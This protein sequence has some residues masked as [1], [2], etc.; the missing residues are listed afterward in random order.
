[1][2]SQKQV[3]RQPDKPPRI[4]SNLLCSGFN[5]I[6]F[7]SEDYISVNGHHLVSHLNHALFLISVSCSAPSSSPSPPPDPDLRTVNKRWKAMSRI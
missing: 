2:A 5:Q 1:M 7:L 6:P 4:S 3:I